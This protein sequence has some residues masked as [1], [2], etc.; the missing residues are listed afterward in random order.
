MM[1]SIMLVPQS[2]AALSFISP[3]NSDWMIERIDGMDYGQQNSIA[4]ASDGSL[5]ISYHDSL[6]GS[7]KYAT[8]ATGIWVTETVDDGS[9]NVVGLGTSIIV[10]P[11]GTVWIAYYD[12][13]EGAVMVAEGQSLSWNLTQVD[14]GEP[15][16][17]HIHQTSI[18]LSSDGSVHLSYTIFDGTERW[19]LYATNEGFDW[20]T[21]PVLDGGEPVVVWNSSMSTVS[22][23]QVS[24]K[25]DSNE[26][27]CIAYARVVSSLGIEKVVLSYNCKHAQWTGDSLFYDGLDPR[28][29]PSLDLDYMDRPFIACLGTDGKVTQVW[30]KTSNWKYNPIVKLDAPQM[31]LKVDED[32]DVHIAYTT[33]DG[34]LYYA[35]KPPALPGRSVLVYAGG[36]GQCAQ[37]SLAVHDTLPFISYLNESASGEAL[38]LTYHSYMGYIPTIVSKEEGYLR[39]TGVAY[40][41]LTWTIPSELEPDVLYYNVYRNAILL[42]S[43]TSKYYNDTSAVPGQYYSYQVTSVTATEEHDPSHVVIGNTVP[44]APSDLAS[45][46]QLGSITLTW[47]AP[48]DGGLGIDGYVVFRDGEQ[49][50]VT[51]NTSYTDTAIVDGYLYVYR[52][53][54]TNSLGMGPDSDFVFGNT[55]PAAVDD[56]LAT[57]QPGNVTLTWTEPL[58]ES[59]ITGYI[60][61]RDGVQIAVLD[62]FNTSLLDEAVVSGESY[63]YTVTAYNNVGE[64][65]LSNV[66]IGYTLPG[67]PFMGDAVSNPDDID[68]WWT[69]PGDGGLEIEAFILRTTDLV[70]EWEITNF[71][72]EEGI[73]RYS[74]AMPPGASYNFTVSARN[75]LGEGAASNPTTGNTVPLAP[76]DLVAVAGPSSAN[77]TWNSSWEGGLPL[78]GYHVYRNGTAEPIA[79]LPPD[80]TWFLDEGLAQV[81]YTYQVMAVNDVGESA[82]ANVSVTPLPPLPVPPSPPTDLN[83]TCLIDA[84]PYV[85]LSWQPPLDDGGSPV[86]YY[87]IYR[88]DSGEE[89]PIGN[90]TELDFEDWDVEM[91][92][93]YTYSVTAVNAVGEGNASSVSIHVYDVPSQP[94]S[95]E[96]LTLVEETVPIIILTW[97]PPEDDGG[98]NITDYVVYKDGELAAV[99]LNTEYTDVDVEPGDEHLYWVCARNALGTGDPS[100]VV[101]GLTNPAAPDLVAE[102]EEGLVT[103]TWSMPPDGGSPI[104]GYTLYRST[105]GEWSILAELHASALSYEDQTVT[106]GNYTYALEAENAIGIGP[107]GEASAYVPDLTPPAIVISS[108]QEGDV[109]HTDSVT[110]VWT[111]TDNASGVQGQWASLDGGEWLETTS[112]YD[113]TGLHN[114]PHTLWVKARDN[115]GN[116]AE[117]EVNITI[118][119]PPTVTFHAPTG[120]GMEAVKSIQVTFSTTMDTDSV[121]ISIPG[122]DGVMQWDG[123][124]V[125]YLLDRYLDVT[126]D[127]T[128]TVTGHDTTGAEMEPFSWTFSTGDF[129]VVIGTIVDSDGQPV[130]GV[131]VTSDG[132]EAI[133]DE[134]GQFEMRLLPGTHV[135][136]V[137]GDGYWDTTF[138]VVIGEEGFQDIGQVTLVEIEIGGMLMIIFLLVLMGAIIAIWDRER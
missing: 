94:L 131:L 24:M 65:N 21:E 84:V 45:Q 55:V 127:Y 57:S 31:S 130:A 126:N 17:G 124:S 78:T 44:A 49:L 27:P 67:T 86:L 120:S 116:E 117:K 93:N 85:Q 121:I 25:L 101:E 7:L 105:G 1:I 125:V 103:L 111:A 42:D 60:V 29:T 80:I 77:L 96:S 89:S 122:Y 3:D 90:T 41:N 53:A 36:D 115:A 91:G 74:V 9:G 109:L 2:S 134:N 22:G 133:T 72:V 129:V 48:A 54:A 113:F 81:E 87:L 52:V 97:D 88:N 20:S 73:V 50:A 35:H 137:K 108:P 51:P 99:V 12:A 16:A 83:A 136:T 59:G 39:G 68:L 56:L 6:N 38:E 33:T 82:P 46:G 28:C 47:Q 13:T 23:G 128:V 64:S 106:W 4:T 18:A 79:I 107:R 114:G 63:N 100:D 69:M 102:G 10:A 98:L 71:T 8:N 119:V 92:M 70:Y 61:Y 32:G 62:R 43:T 110:L 40:V 135:L 104:T 112:P 15:L 95:L 66:A 118:A 75:S 19:L 132:Q 34:I 76:V 26:D 14:D 138:E 5:H 58:S 37:P 30:I 11:N 123:Q